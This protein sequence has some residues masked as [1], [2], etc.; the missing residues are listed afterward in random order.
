MLLRKLRQIRGD[1]LDAIDGLSSEQLN[2]KPSDED[3]SISQILYHLYLTE[4]EKTELMVQSINYPGEKFKAETEPPEYFLTRNE[5][6]QLLEESRF[7]Y[8]RALLN[9]I[10]EEN[11]TEVSSIHPKISYDSLTEY[12]YLH[13]QRHIVQIKDIKQKV[14]S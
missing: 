13:E 2:I 8:V 10:D 7:Q 14:I 3:W 1:L 5:L 4:K 11:L 12:V 6:L 9:K